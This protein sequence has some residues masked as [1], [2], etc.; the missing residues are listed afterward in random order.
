MP[1]NIFTTSDRSY[2]ITL[3]HEPD[4]FFETAAASRFGIYILAFETVFFEIFKKIIQQ[5]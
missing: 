5:G 1:V 2:L 4:F 3:A